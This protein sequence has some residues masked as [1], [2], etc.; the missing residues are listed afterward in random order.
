MQTFFG[1][2]YFRIDI[3]EAHEFK[4]Q[5]DQF[6]FSDSLFHEWSKIQ[7]VFKFVIYDQGS[8][9]LS[10]RLSLSISLGLS[11][12]VSLGLGLNLSLGLA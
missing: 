12:N 11:L 10:L 8:K 6:S 5:Q 1:N 4:S 7:D 3:K 9:G 2:W